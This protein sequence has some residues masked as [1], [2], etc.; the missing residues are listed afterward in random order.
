MKREDKNKCIIKRDGNTIT[1]TLNGLT[2]TAVLP[3]GIETHLTKVLCETYERNK[4]LIDRKLD[5]L[6]KNKK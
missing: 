1:A 5:E 2:A 3:D 6:E 4:E